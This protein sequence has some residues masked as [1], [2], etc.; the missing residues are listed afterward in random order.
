MY[1]APALYC[2][3]LSGINTAALNIALSESEKIDIG[4]KNTYLPL[5][6][7]LVNSYLNN[8]KIDTICYLF[9][10]IDQVICK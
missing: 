8:S 2:L 3:P 6:D 10:K 4:Y 5:L 9:H 7:L 1:F